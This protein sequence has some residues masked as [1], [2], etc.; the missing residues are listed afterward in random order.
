[1]TKNVAFR[2]PANPQLYSKKL[3]LVSKSLNC[4][5]V[6]NSLHVLLWRVE[7]LLEDIERDFHC[8]ASFEY[9]Y[10]LQNTLL[11]H[12]YTCPWECQYWALEWGSNPALLL[13]GLAT[14]LCQPH[15][16]AWDGMA[17]VGVRDQGAA[18]QL[19]SNSTPQL[20]MGCFMLA[21]MHATFPKR[22]LEMSHD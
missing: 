21:G 12:I 22:G 17:G 13:S 5:M 18:R 8:S 16:A 2:N 3:Q 1:M 20:L 11:N 7:R 9:F 19:Q 14:E 15:L 4:K 6:W 10:N